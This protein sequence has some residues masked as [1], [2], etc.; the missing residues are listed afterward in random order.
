MSY[1]ILKLKRKLV[2]RLDL[3]DVVPNKLL[4]KKKI[5]NLKIFYGNEEKELSDFFSI[6]GKLNKGIIFK[7]NLEKCDYIG[8][9]MTQGIIIIKG[10]AGE[11]LGNQMKGGKII[12]YGSSGNY[13]A[14]SLKN[15]EIQIKNNTGDYL[16][17]SIQGNKIGMSGGRVIVSGNAGNFLASKMRSGIIFVAGSVKDYL[18]SQ[19]IA[20]TVI[21]NGK[22]GKNPGLLMKRGT[23]ILK[24]NISIPSY[25]KLTGKN[26]YLFLKIL[27]FYL[28]K[29]NI[30]F[31]NIFANIHVKK[32][33]GDSSCKGK[34][35]I[36]ILN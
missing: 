22:I 32:L 16:G 7:G 2:F 18:G 34:G 3:R 17:S 14:N 4:G 5:N 6:Q 29:I 9:S 10:N 30:I 13:T 36:L 27:E 15:G 35:E 21:I 1:L 23:I 24:N 31:K 19:M 33:V 11:Y 12:V 25:F 28:K 8:D 26:N 20:G